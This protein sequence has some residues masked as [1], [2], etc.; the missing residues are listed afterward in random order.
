LA[1]LEKIATEFISIGFFSSICHSQHV[2]TSKRFDEG[3]VVCFYHK[4]DP[5]AEM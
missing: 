1:N 3:K 5:K 4:D 2:K